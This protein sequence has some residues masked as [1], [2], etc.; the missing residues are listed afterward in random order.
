MSDP[1]TPEQ[2][3]KNARWSPYWVGIHDKSRDFIIHSIKRENLGKVAS[4]N[5]STHWEELEFQIKDHENSS[6]AVY[7]HIT[8][9]LFVLFNSILLCPSLDSR[10]LSENPSYGRVDGENL[11][12]LCYVSL[13]FARPE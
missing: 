8:L 7:T 6:P 2:Y 10:Q 13:A 12:S 1:H 11:S 9:N 5:S 3:L 4:G